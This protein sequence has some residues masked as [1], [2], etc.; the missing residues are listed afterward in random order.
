MRGLYREPRAAGVYVPGNMVQGLQGLQNL[1]SP[2]SC[3]G[4]KRSDTQASFASVPKKRL[5]MSPALLSDQQ[6]QEDDPAPVGDG[7]HPDGGHQTIVSNDSNLTPTLLEEHP[8]NQL[9]LE[10]PVT[11]TDFPT[12]APVPEIPPSQPRSPTPPPVPPVPKMADPEPVPKPSGSKGQPARRAVSVDDDEGDMYKDGT[13]WKQLDLRTCTRVVDLGWIGT[14]PLI[15]RARRRRIRSCSSCGARVKAASWPLMSVHLFTCI[16]G[17]KIRVL[18]YENDLK[19]K[20]VNV[21]MERESVQDPI[22]LKS[23][24]RLL[25]GRG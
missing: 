15:G 22:V 18:L 21:S 20:L 4:L 12:N 5:A 16:R 13:Y 1:G 9:G 11:P 17:K 23:Y 25:G 3:S 24:I 10:A 6:A 14:S 19:M 7:Y 8:D 2:D